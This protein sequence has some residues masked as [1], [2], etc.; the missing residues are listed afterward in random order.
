MARLLE[1]EWPT[2]GISVV[3]EPLPYNQDYYHY[4]LDNCPIEGIQSHAVVSGKLLYIMNLRLSE[5]PRQRYME[6]TMEDLAEADI[7][8]IFVFVTF[9]KVG[10]IMAKYGEI[11]EPMSYPTIAQVRNEDM[12]KL[13]QAGK[14][15]WDA[16]YRSKE[17]IPVIYREK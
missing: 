10:S 7:G 16:I 8:R 15:E 3:S 9:G 2:L 11:T 14:A 1:M 5:F 17:I 13:R 12:D 6:L 4:F